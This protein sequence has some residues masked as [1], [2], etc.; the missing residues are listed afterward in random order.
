MR[1]EIPLDKRS[2][3]DVNISRSGSKDVPRYAA[4]RAPDGS[5][6][7]VCDGVRHLQD[8]IQ[9]KAGTCDMSTIVARYMSGDTSAAGSRPGFYDD[10][11]QMPRNLLEA[12]TMLINARSTFDALPADVRQSFDND[13]Q[14]WLSTAGSKDWIDHMSVKPV[15][16]DVVKEAK[17]LE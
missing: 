17:V 10:A 8:E 6:V 12:Q 9:A 7:I 13:F 11:T 2:A 1:N 16:V 15:E 5:L 4:K 14:N 3:F